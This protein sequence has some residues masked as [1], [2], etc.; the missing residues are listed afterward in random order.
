MTQ[1]KAII[2]QNS[3]KIIAVVLVFTRMKFLLTAYK[4]IMN[5]HRNLHTKALIT[6]PSFKIHR[7][8]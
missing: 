4:I 7:Q 2:R 5:D 1:A 3:L 6:T 8:F